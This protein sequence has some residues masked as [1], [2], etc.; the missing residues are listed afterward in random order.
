M[1][2]SDSDSDGIKIDVWENFWFCF[3]LHSFNFNE[4]VIDFFLNWTDNK[5]KNLMISSF[6]FGKHLF[7]IR[8]FRNLKILLFC[9]DLNETPTIDNRDVFLDHERT[10]IRV[11]KKK[12]RN[13]RDRIDGAIFVCEILCTKIAVCFLNDSIWFC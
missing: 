11:E 3:K 4:S 13:T 9:W 7:V 6:H 1:F 5:K 2:W 8:Y 12:I 10:Y